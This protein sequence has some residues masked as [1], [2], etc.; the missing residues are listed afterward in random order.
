MT[1]PNSA[2]SR[3]DAKHA[4]PQRRKNKKILATWRPLATWRDIQA[5]CHEHGSGTICTQEVLGGGHCSPTGEDVIHDQGS[6]SPDN[7][8]IATRCGRGVNSAPT[9]C[10]RGQ[11]GK[12]SG[13][14]KGLCKWTLLPT[15]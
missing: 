11:P 1:L 14:R 5:C 2:F 4:K 9:S 10:H 6:S 15:A 7:R 3:Q 12:E 8:V 13:L